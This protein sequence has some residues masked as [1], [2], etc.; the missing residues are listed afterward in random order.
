LTQRQHQPSALSGVACGRNVIVMSAES[1]QAF[2]IGLELMGQA[3][4]PN[5]S[6]FA[7]ESLHFVNIYDQTHLL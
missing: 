4:T 3:V 1:L 6:A 2:P 5:L 7:R